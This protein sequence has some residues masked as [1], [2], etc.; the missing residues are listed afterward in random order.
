MVCAFFGHRVIDE[1][2]EVILKA[3]IIDLIENKNVTTFLVGHNGAFDNLVRSTLKKLLLAYPKIRFFV[4]LAYRPVE[5]SKNQNF[6][7]SDT[8]YPDALANVPAR[9]AIDKRNRWLIDNCDYV[10]TY[11]KYPGGAA[12]FSALAKKKGKIVISLVDMNCD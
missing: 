2:L 12:R 8:I 7:F 1:D 3:S 6:D 11:A 10:I 5:K 9:Y 4:V